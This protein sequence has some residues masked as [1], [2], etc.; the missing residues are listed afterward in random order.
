MLDFTADPGLASIRLLASDMDLTLLAD[1]K[2]MPCGLTER[3]EALTAAGV[4]FCAASG[5]PGP[6]LR[7]M[8]PES[9]HLMGFISDN[10]AAVAYGEK[11]VFKSLI[12]PADYQELIA[13]T[14][15]ET[16]GV[17]VLC[18]MES[19][20]V[21]AAHKAHDAQIREYYRTITYLDSFDGLAVEANKY[22]V[23]FPQN[24]SAENFERVFRPRF[25][26]RFSV[27]CAGVE[28]V[29][30]MNA[31]VTK[32]TGVEALC[33]HLGVNIADAAAI[34]DTDN[35]TQ[36]LEAVGHSFLVA[37]APERM[38]AHARYLAPSN[39]D[40]GVIQL[41]DAILAARRAH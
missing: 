25:G 3:I 32:A 34:G 16:S 1:D 7:Q 19:A 30:V 36:M 14:L 18:G 11:P 28:W 8:F 39:N 29:D 26:E 20:Y 35:D 24:D 21:L 17:P 13:A 5:R 12:D 33:A 9:A 23:L 31:G 15:S 40:A 6:T 37:N 2:S 22:T 41:I 10:G 4:T 27:T 38:R